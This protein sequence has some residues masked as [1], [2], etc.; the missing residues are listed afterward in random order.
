MS[1]RIVNPTATT[2]TIMEEY[3]KKVEETLEFAGCPQDLRRKILRD[4]YKTTEVYFSANRPYKRDTANFWDFCLKRSLHTSI[5]KMFPAIETRNLYVHQVQ[6][7]DSIL[8]S[9]TTIIST[10]TGSGKTESFL[11]PLLHYCLK[12]RGKQG[13]KV[14]ILY[15]INA[16]AGD[17]LRRINEA[18]AGQNITVGCFVGSTPDAKRA[19][20]VRNP[21]DI[22]ITNYV[23][24]DRLITKGNTRSIFEN[25]QQTLRYL[26]VDEIH[27]YRGTKGANLCLLLRRLRALCEGTN[28]LIQIGASATLRRGGG[29]YSDDDQ[30][31]LQEYVRS[32]F[33]QDALQ[34][35]EFVTPIYDDEQDSEHS[36]DPFPVTDSIQGEPL[37]IETDFEAIRALAEQLAGTPIPRL[38]VG[39]QQVD[40]LY[41]FAKRNQFVQRLSTKLKNQAC[42]IG[43]F[44]ELFR[45]V[46]QE[47][48][49]CE[50]RNPRDVVYAY[51]SL[52]NGIN[53]RFDPNSHSVPEV[54]LDYRLHLI[55]DDLGGCLTQ[56]L[57]CG[58]YHDGRR[59]HCKFCN[60]ILFKVSKKNPKLCIA[61]CNGAIL[62]PSTKE[63]SPNTFPVLVEVLEGQ[64]SSPE[65]QNTFFLKPHLGS[66]EEEESYILS[67]ARDQPGNVHI[68]WPTDNGQIE[69][70]ELEQPRLYWQNVQ[71]IVD[72]ILI[73]HEMAKKL[74][75]FIDNREKAS[76][77]RFRLRDEIAERA[78]TMWAKENWSG[79]GVLP[80]TTAYRRLE[81]QVQ[82]SI[83]EK[84]KVG[85][86]L[87]EVVQ[88]MPFWFARMLTRLPEY[89]Q[90]WKIHLAK[91]TAN[92]LQEDE[93]RLI[94]EVFLLH[95]A[96]DRSEFGVPN[97][98]NLNHFFIEKYRVAIEYGVGLSSAKEQGYDVVSLGVQ[99]KIYQRI[100]DSIGSDRIGQLLSSLNDHGILECKQTSKGVLFYQLNPQHLVLQCQFANTISSKISLNRITRIECHTADNTSKERSE[101]EDRFRDGRIHALICTPTLEMGIDIGDLSCVMM[102]GFPPSP[103]SYA[104]RAGRAGRSDRSRSATMVVLASS[105]N[106]HDG[107]Y[108]AEP[109]KMINGTITPPQ[110]TLTNMKLLATHSSAYLLA[111]YEGLELFT[112][113]LKLDQRIEQFINTDELNLRSELHNDYNDFAK[114]FDEYIRKFFGHIRTH[115]DGYRRGLFPDYGFRRDGIPLIDPNRI[116]LDKEDSDAGILTSREPEGAVYKLAPGRVVYCSGRP[117]RVEQNQPQFTYTNDKDP[118][119]KTFR[120][121]TQFI[122]EK[123]DELYVYAK[124]DSDIKYQVIRTLWVKEAASQLKALGPSYCW[125]A[126]IR[127]GK[128]FIVNEGM[129]QREE[130][131]ESMPVMPFH[132]RRDDY[133]IG[134]CLQRDGLLIY[135]HESILAPD[136]RANFLAILLRSI[137]DYFN[138]DDGELRIASS[139]KVYST[140]DTTHDGRTYIFLYG[141]D[142]SGLVPFERIFD[143]LHNMLN[144]HLDVLEK[145][146]CDDGCYHCLFSFNS[147][148][149]TGTLSRQRAAHFLSAY[150]QV[151]LLEPHI[152]PQ[153]KSFSLQPDVV[154]R[155]TWRNACEVLAERPRIRTSTPYH[156]E[157]N[158]MDQNTVIY[159]T[160]C[161]ALLTE[162]TNGARTVKIYCKPSYVAA[163]LCGEMKVN[164][165]QEAFLQMKLAL[166]HWDAWEA[167]GIN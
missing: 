59:T 88:E 42:T 33:G 11:I 4:L 97:T 114:Y 7:I 153:R 90:D 139:V 56:C 148:Y 41:Q 113:A 95:G 155:V 123:N 46:Y 129:H 135:L 144:K 89:D 163:Q 146:S 166:L 107:Y 26:V 73:K 27:Y 1:S 20:M 81:T 54:L 162:F 119:G 64:V 106:N 39:R 79:S 142:E 14:I 136:T 141:H 2:F 104:Q 120:S 133:R 138:L 131:Q 65:L 25:S 71:R 35:F 60:G 86:G 143:H 93:L 58:R 5:S 160:I 52:M 85:D 49:Q 126:L 152:S 83:H 137:P 17:Q 122:A 94:N 9:H 8:A 51:L 6:A 111:G 10:G 12:Q 149:L 140:D 31:Q 157:S 159:Q 128:L 108:M 150:L 96:V 125:V 98:E 74:L 132:D 57:L 102:I 82:Y 167:E 116:N 24:L 43:D 110:F 22:L 80:L 53:S 121:Y 16:L 21:P 78:L 76:G 105:S 134:A 44:V 19:E 87:I 50:P 63:S 3:Q 156:S 112:H 84:E 18:V 77:I 68:S 101:S 40:P 115:E 151:S 29:Y 91:G 34:D 47:N 130:H 72:A 69:P 158:G 118:T 99:G 28:Q 75:S 15:P 37:L 32:L 62:S 145:C 70:L 124:Q 164:K 13:I 154:L 30:T 45:Q 147:Q 161:I 117:V 92:G 38:H 36:T 67:P 100:I 103:A 165:G 55:L 61:Q 66:D 109:R 48:H 127:K 23:M